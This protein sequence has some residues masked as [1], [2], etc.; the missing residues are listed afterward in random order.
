MK[1]SKDS[2]YKNNL[3]KKFENEAIALKDAE[4]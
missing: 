3:D 4:K 2:I 1:K